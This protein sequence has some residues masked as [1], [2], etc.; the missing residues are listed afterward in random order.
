MQL[1]ITP[2][3][4][5]SGLSLQ[6][7][8]I[9]LG[10]KNFQNIQYQEGRT[11]VSFFNC[12]FVD[13]TIENT[14]LINFQ[15]VSIGFFNCA[16]VNIQ[17]ETITSNNI[18]VGFYGSIIS[19][20]IKSENIS[21]VAFNNC[22]IP[23]SF[24][25]F[26]VPIVNIGYTPENISDNHWNELCHLLNF[27]GADELVTASIR[28][29]LYNIKKINCSSTFQNEN[30]NRFTPSLYI[31]YE[32]EIDNIE[33]KVIGMSLRYLTIG[34]K[35]K[36]KLS[37]ENC[38]IDSWFV[39][40]FYPEGDISFYDIMPLSGV[41]GTDAI[42]GINRCNLDK[43]WFDNISFDLYQRISFYRT[44]FSKAIFTSC[45]FP[46]SYITFAKFI[47]AENVLNPEKTP[48]NFAKAQYEIF[49]QLKKALE[50]TGNYYE[51]QKLQ[52]IAH[53][54]LQRIDELTWWDKTILW[55]NGQSN[56][57]GLSIRQP[58]VG[59]FIFSIPIYILYLWGIGRMFD[60]QAE[61]DYTLI[62]YYFSF[63][64]ITHR[65]DFLTTNK[66]ILAGWPLF[67]DYLGKVVVGF[68]IY[69]FITAF[70][71]YAK[72]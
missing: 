70:R 48:K 17:V 14:D 71:K 27:S 19:G 44:K 45:D 36:G 72:R 13:L 12:R 40:D 39:Y 69:Q 38:R 57:H 18:S 46:D 55:I 4:P 47:E 26:D 33:A 52:A 10:E 32:K 28:Y 58:L 16:I 11:T 9:K 64:D 66:S 43:V 50:D 49:L 41:G 23:N 6:T 2:Y 8:T 3:N 59:F 7:A 51:S 68:F 67:F 63:I 5:V 1:P 15:D 42:I 29:Y 24:F 54:A 60:C 30:R 20:K 53:D 61:I 25:V 35:P 62:G 31:S 22:L 34:G 56:N 21:A 65:A 37:V